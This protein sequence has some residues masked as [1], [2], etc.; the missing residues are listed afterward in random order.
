[1]TG[2]TDFRGEVQR[3]EG[4]VFVVQVCSNQRWLRKVRSLSGSSSWGASQDQQTPGSAPALTLSPVP[5][6]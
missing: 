4:K 6:R 3:Q 2:T 5:D 1:M